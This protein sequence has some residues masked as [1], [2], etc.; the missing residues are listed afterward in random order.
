M[1][2]HAAVPRFCAECEKLMLGSLPEGR[3]E[4]AGY[5]PHHSTLAQ[6]TIEPT[7]IIRA[8]RLRGPLTEEQAAIMVELAA[9]M[10]QEIFAREKN[11]RPKSH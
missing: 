3:S 6:V 9:G 11:S 4:H 10:K 1:S 7:G 8:W 2:K 5:C